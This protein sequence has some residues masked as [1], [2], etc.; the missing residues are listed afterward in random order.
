[1]AEIITATGWQAH[2]VRGVVSILGSKGG[3]KI[4]SAKND[5]GK[6]AGK[7][8]GIIGFPKALVSGA[9][10]PAFYI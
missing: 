4:E 10:P 5:S 2:M 8:T 7:H 6:N 1:L 9:E 3:A